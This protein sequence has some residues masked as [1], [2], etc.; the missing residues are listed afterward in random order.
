MVA[1]WRSRTWERAEISSRSFAARSKSFSPALAEG[2]SL[3][4]YVERRV[5]AASA[6]ERSEVA[7][8]RV[9]GGAGGE[10]PGILISGGDHYVG[11]ALVVFE[12][13]VEAR[14]VALYQG[15]LEHQRLGLAR[16]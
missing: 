2:E 11:V 6:R 12:R 14:P 4:Q 5:D 1:C 3:V 9:V 13:G 15:R 16:R 8:A 10:Y 7:V